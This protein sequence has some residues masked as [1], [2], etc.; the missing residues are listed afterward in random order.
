MSVVVHQLSTKSSQ[1][2][3]RKNRG[4][5]TCTAF[6]PTKPLFL[7]ATENNVRVY[8]LAKQTLAKKLLAGGGVITSVAVHSSGD[9]VLL[10]TEDSR[11]LWCAPS[12][13]LATRVT[14]LL[15]GS[16]TGTRVPQG[17]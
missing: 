14:A 7:V 4:R 1:N 13:L 10:G 12:P 16:A 15:R 6:H 2:P 3:F 8:N 17:G 9:H 5:V 11:C